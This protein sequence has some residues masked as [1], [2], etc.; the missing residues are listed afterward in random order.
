M[1]QANVICLLLK[2]K[3]VWYA[4]KTHTNKQTSHFPL[5]F[6]TRDDWSYRTQQSRHKSLHIKVFRKNASFTTNKMSK[7]SIFIHHI[8]VHRHIKL[9]H[10][11]VQNNNDN[12]IQNN[13]EVESYRIKF[14]QD[15]MKRDSCHSQR[16]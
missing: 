10:K 12:D 4:Y 2:C 5:S 11:T 16:I 7:E 13:G 9:V 3:C 1:T 6:G 14:S 15:K 8:N